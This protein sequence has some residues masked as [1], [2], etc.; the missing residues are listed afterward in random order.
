MD[1][2]DSTWEFI[3]TLKTGDED[4]PASNP[5]L[6]YGDTIEDIRKYFSDLEEQ[7]KGLYDQLRIKFY[8]RSLG[9]GARQESWVLEGRYIDPT[10]RLLYGKS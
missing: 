1:K 6:E 2:K 7:H 5:F 9:H 3:T 4:F 8:S 10:K